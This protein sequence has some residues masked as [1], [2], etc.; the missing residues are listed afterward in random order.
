MI[1]QD[2]LKKL[3]IDNLTSLWKKMSGEVSSQE[4]LRKCTEWPYRVWVDW[5][6][7][8]THLETSFVDLPKNAVVT[9]WG[10]VDKPSTLEELLLKAS[11]PILF[12]QVAMVLALDEY[13]VPESKVMPLR[14][15]KTTYDLRRWVA[16]ASA[17]FGYQVSES[18]IEKL[19]NDD[20]IK[21]LFLEREG[22]VVATALLYK[23][24]GVIGIH[25]VG[26]LPSERGQGLAY[27]VMLQVIKVCKEWRG[28]YISLQAS[29]M[30]LST[31]QRLG[32]ESQFE[33][34]NYSRAQI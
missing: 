34:R 20:S 28:Q 33:I 27:E 11:W 30:G 8:T 22:E 10:N 16:V 18:V 12:T 2:A 29:A 17:S 31:Y 3:N 24:G 13:A 25:Q 6:D 15:V 9:V 32:F 5:G 14:E 4:P 19:T 1:D 21:L 23:T 7:S 26:V